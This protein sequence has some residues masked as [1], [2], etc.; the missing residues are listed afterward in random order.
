MLVTGLVFS[1][2]GVQAGQADGARPS[3]QSTTIAPVT[4]TIYHDE[5]A[6]ETVDDT[7]SVQ[8]P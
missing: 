2:L 8:V 7:E 1:T 4:R 6:Y 3:P 5:V